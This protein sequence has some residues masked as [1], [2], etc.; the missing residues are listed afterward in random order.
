M[1]VRSPTAEAGP[2]EEEAPC[3]RPRSPRREVGDLDGRGLQEEK[4]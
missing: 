4:V 3:G 2:A 1:K